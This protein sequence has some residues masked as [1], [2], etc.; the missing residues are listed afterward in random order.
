[1][2]VGKECQWHS[3]LSSAAHCA[4][5]DETS[6]KPWDPELLSFTELFIRKKLQLRNC[7]SK[8]TQVRCTKP[9][10]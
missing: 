8:M 1:M 9:E 4:N 2:V 3:V 10:R 6:C 5:L 7:P